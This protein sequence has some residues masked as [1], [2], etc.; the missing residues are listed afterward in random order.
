M[1]SDDEPSNYLVGSIEERGTGYD[2]ISP[3][4]PLGKALL[5]HAP[6]DV[7]TFEARLCS[8]ERRPPPRLGL[9][10]PGNG[11][12]AR[13]SGALAEA[14]S[15]AASHPF[16]PWWSVRRSSADP[17]SGLVTSISQS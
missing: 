16:A 7:V 14:G 13:N 4:S 5:G 9:K 11:E 15:A 1:E 2:V 12:H 6:G 3:A 8:E 17:A 10:A